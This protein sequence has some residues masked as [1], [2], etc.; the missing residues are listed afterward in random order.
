MV[1]HRPPCP[2]CRKPVAC[3]EVDG[4]FCPHCA[5]PISWGVTIMTMSEGT[6]RTVRD[7]GHWSIRTDYCEY[8]LGMSSPVH[9]YNSVPRRKAV[10][11]RGNVEY[12][13]IC[14]EHFPR[15]EKRQ[16][17]YA[18]TRARRAK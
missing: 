5:A 4:D 7:M 2:K 11:T 14:D 13:K 12:E 8:C 6:P 16:E 17:R 1:T 10:D 3:D 15:F 9:P 18:R